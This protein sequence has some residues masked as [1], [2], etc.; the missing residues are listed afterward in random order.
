MKENVEA[1]PCCSEHL[2]GKDCQR[3]VA[4]AFAKR[5]RAQQ[6]DFGRALASGKNGRPQS[7]ALVLCHLMK[8]D[9]LSS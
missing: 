3:K 4:A 6:T 5:I 2:M 9:C 8:T 1:E 7:A